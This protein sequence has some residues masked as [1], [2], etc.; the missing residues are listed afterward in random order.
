M[1]DTRNE[2]EVIILARGGGDAAQLLPFSDE[3]LCRAI[4]A[5]ATPVVSA[6][7]H[8]GDRP[9][10]DEVADHRYGT[11]SLAAAAVIP[12]R[13]ELEAEL[14]RFA[15]LAR[16]T[17]EE[18]VAADGARLAALDRR[19]ALET[20]LVGAVRRLGEGASRLQLV[21]PA[22]SVATAGGRLARLDWR[23]SVR[24]RAGHE[25]DRLAAAR[26]HLD[27]LSPERVLDRGYAVVRSASGSVV[28]GADELQHGDVL[29]IQLARG[30][31]GAVVE[32]V[33]VPT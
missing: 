31:A 10:C 5:S 27:A 14:E 24:R 9:L 17:I 26:R 32:E 13:S 6:V 1:L 18:R 19:E 16:S 3:A 23:Q 22:R 11:P 25:H 30:S 7:G 20:A 15:K 12:A 33:H 8:E 28:R 4:A 21:H 2:V 29:A